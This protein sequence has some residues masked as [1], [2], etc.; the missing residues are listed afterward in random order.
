MLTLPPVCVTL[1][2]VCNFYHDLNK[3][4]D[5]RV[6][7]KD[8]AFCHL[9]W[10]DLLTQT[11]WPW[12]SKQNILVIVN[13]SHWQESGSS[14]VNDHQWS[15]IESM[16]ITGRSSHY[17]DSFRVLRP[18]ITWTWIKSGS[19]TQWQPGCWLDS[20]TTITATQAMQVNP[21]PL[22]HTP[23]VTYRQTLLCNIYNPDNRFNWHDPSCCEQLNLN[24]HCER[25][26]STNNNRE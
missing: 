2:V 7:K 16:Q 20:R 4:T 11:R 3:Q 26:R 1:L 24:K 5:G 6:N 12:V 15:Q 18:N 9:H 21:Q 22:V 13:E 25:G 14:W 19:Q 17:L 8:S 10:H 23:V